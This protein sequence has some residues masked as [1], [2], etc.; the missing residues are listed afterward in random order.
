[1][2]RMEFDFKELQKNVNGAQISMDAYI[3]STEKQIE[4]LEGKTDKFMEAL[5]AEMKAF[6]NMYNTSR[7]VHSMS[8]TRFTYCVDAL[9]RF[10]VLS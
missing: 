4:E 2:L 9:H 6:D 8:F 1:M 3:K 7:I 5:E 10:N